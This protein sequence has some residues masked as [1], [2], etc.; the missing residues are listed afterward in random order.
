MHDGVLSSFLNKAAG[1]MDTLLMPVALVAA[2]VP[3]LWFVTCKSR[4]R[5]KGLI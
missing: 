3:V 1:D 4:K 5:P 2:K